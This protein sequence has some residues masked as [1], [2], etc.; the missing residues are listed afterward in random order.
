MTFTDFGSATGD[1]EL[2]SHTSG[3]AVS[4]A[5]SA[6][7]SP[8]SL[9]DQLSPIPGAQ[10]LFTWLGYW[11]DFHDAEVLSLHLDRSGP[12][13]LCIQTRKLNA[14][15]YF[16]HSKDVIVEFIFERIWA[17][18]LAGF[19]DQNVIFGL[20]IE[21]A[22]DGYTVVLHDCF[23]LSGSISAEGLAIT[24]TPGNPA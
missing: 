20:T 18:D 22:R 12:S 13:R 11:P 15:G 6:P 2:V 14:A 24:S 16:V 7:N 21:T 10:E 23:G 9:P 3:H 19:N 1:I 17:L 5:R 4:A 8:M